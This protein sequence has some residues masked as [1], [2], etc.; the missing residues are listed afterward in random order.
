MKIAALQ[1]ANAHAQNEIESYMKAAVE[2]KVKVILFG[3]YVL[4][5]FFKDLEKRCGE[6]LRI[7]EAIKTETEAILALSAKYNLIMVA[8][9]FEILTDK[10]YKTILILN[11][12][13]A[14]HYRSQR[15]MP[16]AHWNEVGFFANTMLKNLKTPPI[17]NV[18]GFKFAPVFGYELH[19]DDFWLKLKKEDVDCVLLPTASTFDSSLRWRNIIKMRAFLNS[20]YI[21]RANRIGQYQDIPTKMIW[22]FYGDSLFASPN[23]EIIDSLG[24][25]EGLLIADMDKKY[26]KEMKDCWQFRK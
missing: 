10:I 5:A 14:L 26:L 21:L 18:G 24:D 11:K 20:C 25:R 16:Y 4:G 23:G 2:A 17:F 19:F 9:I 1:L 6:K 15:L 3:E 12:G 7:L 13:K 22:N 8:P